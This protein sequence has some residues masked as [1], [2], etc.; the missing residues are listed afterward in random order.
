MDIF[1]LD[2]NE[3]LKDVQDCAPEFTV[4]E[5]IVTYSDGG[6]V[7]VGCYD[8]QEATEN[9]KSIADLRRQY[10]KYGSKS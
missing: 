8:Q 1:V 3:S 2:A 6:L 7:Y 5:H 4:W 9:R 10:Q